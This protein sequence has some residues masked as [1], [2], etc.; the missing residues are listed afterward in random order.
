MGVIL[1]TMFPT[2]SS[3]EMDRPVGFLQ[4]SESRI[5]ATVDTMSI[6]DRILQMFIV[7]MDH[8][9]SINQ[10]EV[11]QVQRLGG[12]LW[13]GYPMDSLAGIVEY[14]SQYK[15]ITPLMGVENV[16]LSPNSYYLPTH[17]GL[18]QISS[19]TLIQLAAQ[20]TS[21]QLKS[22]GYH[23][24]IHHAPNDQ[25]SEE[26]M[27]RFAKKLGKTAES[28]QHNNMM[29]VLGETKLYY[30]RMRDTLKRDSLLWVYKQVARRGL[31]GLSMDQG[32]IDKINPGAYKKNL[33]QRRIKTSALF[34]GLLFATM[35]DSL[36][37]YNAWAEQ[38]AKSGAD[39]IVLTPE[40]IVPVYKA[41]LKVYKENKLTVEDLNEHVVRI[42]QAKEWTGASDHSLDE[43][44][45]EFVVF[46]VSAR[47]LN[48]KME[49]STMT[50]VRDVDKL[51]PLNDLK[52]AAV[53]L[54]TLG[55]EMPVLLNQ[56]RKYGPVSHTHITPQ[57]NG[58]LPFLDARKFRKYDP[59]IL[60]SNIGE[61]DTIKHHAFWAS[62]KELDQNEKIMVINFGEL[63]GLRPFSEFFN[64][65]QVYHKEEF[66]QELLGQ[67]LFG[68]L[69]LNNVLPLSLNSSLTYGEGKWL[70]K[71][72]LSYGPPE[73]KGLDPVAL[74]RID[75]I[76]YEGLNN[77]AFPGCQVLVVKDGQVV[78]DKAFGHHT[79][80]R[81]RPTLR[82]DLYDIASVTKVAATTIGVMRMVDD[83]KMRLNHRL[84][85]YFE[86]ERVVLDSIAFI[87]TS[88]IAIQ[89]E[90]SSADSL[91]ADSTAAIQIIPV[92]QRYEPGLIIDTLPH[93]EDSL[94]I[95]TTRIGGKS[96]QDSRIFGL[97][98][99]DLLT[100]H[101]GLPAGLPIR[102]F[103]LSW[104]K[105]YGRY[106]KYFRPRKDPRHTVQVADRFFM[107]QDY[108][109]TLWQ[110][111]K[112]LELAPGKPYKYSDVN[113]F[114][115]Q[116]AI[117]SVNRIPIDSFLEEKIYGP[118]GLQ[119]IRF[120]PRKEIRRD[121][122]IPTE[123]D[124]W[125]NQLLRG[126]VHDPTA[127]LLGG[128]SGNAGLFSNAGDLAHLFQM[129]VQEG[130]YGGEQFIKK[131]TI[132]NFTS[133]QKG[134]RGYGF[135]MVGESG[136]NFAAYMAPPSTYGHTGFTGTC[137]WVDPDNDLIYIFLANR[138]HP[139]VSNWTLNELRIRQRI[140][141]AIYEAMVN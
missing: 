106:G 42:F 44:N 94:M 32:E 24:F 110:K 26:N 12:F 65:I 25:F 80:A 128:V 59:I 2:Y 9:S 1:Y 130:E 107:R 51:L 95:I 16:R 62:L 74:S 81:R 79:Y 116:Q 77:L 86:D 139:R 117:D 98:V 68:G 99:K 38:F 78:Y 120:N 30:P 28:V 136:N 113:F 35:P 52:R 141:E 54:I 138:V 100:H 132:N 114:L 97:K 47:L 13:N 21:R 84:S 69:E 46:P 31:S 105:G 140:H 50:V 17:A 92:V 61:I 103:V 4:I 82:T 67:A 133:V 55:E 91:G 5:E 134:N 63:N 83:R 126:Y 29:Y 72:R 60:A 104:K 112:G 101:S 93:N 73:E 43:H 19:D 70:R 6:R 88:F 85:R 8:D 96:I 121:R 3:Q 118:M 56:M 135:D 111:T 45:P 137:V 49:Q 71:S 131:R 89:K 10:K 119:Y 27:I 87:D 57:A 129:L 37:D 109:D 90:I 115:L 123:R 22:W 108:L 66:A 64:L 23:F 40:Q 76:V 125:R 11:Q 34:E 20:T 39:M 7:R 33:I 75:T 18:G 36:L 122:L 48:R 53:H 127:A 41:I 102:D 15:G 14:L 58:P 124:R